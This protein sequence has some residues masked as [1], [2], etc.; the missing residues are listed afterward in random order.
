MSLSLPNGRSL[1]LHYFCLSSPEKSVAS[2][3]S[4]KIRMRSI[5]TAKDKWKAGS[6]NRAGTQSYGKFHDGVITVNTIDLVYTWQVGGPGRRDTIL[7]K[8]I[9]STV[10]AALCYLLVHRP[11]NN[12]FGSPG[13]YSFASLVSSSAWCLEHRQHKTV[14]IGIMCGYD[15]GQMCGASCR[16]DTSTSQSSR[17]RE[18][19][20]FNHGMS[21][22]T[23]GY[24]VC[25]A[26]V[27]H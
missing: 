8:P 4:C 12:Q 26:S 17:G 25:A 10:R 5:G 20:L 7:T 15:A 13:K 16:I 11:A 2:T 19:A 9:E 18:F 21:L 1:P 3:A 27:A 14:W 23:C 24:V 22:K 6:K